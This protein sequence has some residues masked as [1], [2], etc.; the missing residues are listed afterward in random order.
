MVKRALTDDER[1]EVVDLMRGGAGVDATM[2]RTGLARST[3]YRIWKEARERD[4]G[5]DV[6]EMTIAGDRM[7]GQLRSVGM[8]KYEGTCKV[9]GGKV[10]RRAFRAPNGREATAQYEAWCAELR[11]ADARRE[12]PPVAVEVVAP[13]PAPE[14]PV[15]AAAV[16]SPAPGPAPVA[17]PAPAPARAE[18]GTAYLVMLLGERPRPYGLYA[19]LERAIEECDTMNAAL[20]FAGVG[21]LYECAEVTWR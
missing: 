12:E 10:R 1:E 20:E 15:A 14:P 17:E 9:S 4:G 2:A 16:E 18:S 5:V 7:H 13:A 19:D 11:D 6:A 3:V 21:K 8:G